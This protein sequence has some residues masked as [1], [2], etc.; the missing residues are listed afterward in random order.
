MDVDGSAVSPDDDDEVLGVV[1]LLVE[2]WN[3]V[4]VA[5]GGVEDLFAYPAASGEMGALLPTDAAAGGDVVVAVV[6]VCWWW[7]SPAL[8]A[9]CNR[10]VVERPPPLLLVVVRDAATELLRPRLRPSFGRL[11]IFDLD[12]IIIIQNIIIMSQHCCCCMRILALFGRPPG[13]GLDAFLH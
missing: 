5:V 12:G 7:F 1:L 11:N 3:K 9:S 2:L 10:R 8:L 6:V 13:C 4:P